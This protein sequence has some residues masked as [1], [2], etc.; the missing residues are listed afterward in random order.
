ME[1]CGIIPWWSFFRVFS[2]FH[3]LFNPINSQHFPEAPRA[4]DTPDGLFIAFPRSGGEFRG[5]LHASV[6]FNFLLNKFLLCLPESEFEPAHTRIQTFHGSIVRRD[7]VLFQAP[8]TVY[9]LWWFL[10]GRSITHTISWI[11]RAASVDR[12]VIHRIILESV[13]VTFARGA[14][15]MTGDWVFPG[16]HCNRFL[17]LTS[18]ITVISR[19]L[20]V[21]LTWFFSLRRDNCRFRWFFR[22]GF[23]IRGFNLSHTLNRA[24][25]FLSVNHIIF[26]TSLVARDN[27]AIFLFN[28]IPILLLLL[29]FISL[30]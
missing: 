26:C 9:F 22:A 6:G 27:S 8:V 1:S 13:K 10:L 24:D 3:S 4:V 7:R 19:G 5:L 30:I 29:V 16:S 14:L 20:A 28:R 2:S 25:Y 17:A 21:T 15:A 11:F 23:P 12:A 18:V